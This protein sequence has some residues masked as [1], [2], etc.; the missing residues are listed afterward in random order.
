MPAHT[1][2]ERKG[3]LVTRGAVARTQRRRRVPSRGRR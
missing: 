2:R 3:R 1:R